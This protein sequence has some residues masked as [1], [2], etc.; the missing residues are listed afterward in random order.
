M[1]QI[2]FSSRFLDEPLNLGANSISQTN[3]IKKTV[4][5]F[6]RLLKNKADIT[7]SLVIAIALEASF[8]RSALQK[9]QTND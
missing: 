8:Y 9:S 2:I 6:A 5:R 3:I 4:K 7:G 1:W